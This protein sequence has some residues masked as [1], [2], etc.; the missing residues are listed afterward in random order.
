MWVLPIFRRRS[1]TKRQ[2]RP[3][4]HSLTHSSTNIAKLIEFVAK[5]FGELSGRQW[6]ERL[7]QMHIAQNLLERVAG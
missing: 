3:M 4:V 6:N 2:M 5:L 1:G 7:H